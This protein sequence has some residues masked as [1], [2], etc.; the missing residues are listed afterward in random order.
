MIE[1]SLEEIE[2]IFVT[3]DL[4]LNHK[5]I[6]K[7]CN[8]PWEFSDKGL[9]EMNQF[10]ISSLMQISAGCT[11]LNLG[12]W[13]MLSHGDTN[14]FMVR[15]VIADLL[16]NGVSVITILGNHDRIFV[17]NAGEKEIDSVK[18]DEIFLQKNDDTGASSVWYSGLEPVLLNGKY[19]LSHEP[20]FI[21]DE[22]KLI[23]HGH[24]H[25]SPLHHKDEWNQCVNE[26][27]VGNYVNCCADV[28][29]YKPVMMGIFNDFTGGGSVEDVVFS[30][31]AMKLLAEALEIPPEPNDNLKG[32]F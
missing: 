10:L 28:H 31:K 12:D 1:L 21:K 5:N 25:N 18:L 9:E 24:I 2:S 23:L 8:R 14:R 15:N 4:H 6:I 16:K 32:L 19:I 30:D 20:V 22:S 3:S 7:Y 27:L 29:N 11:L 26:K 17:K 13:A